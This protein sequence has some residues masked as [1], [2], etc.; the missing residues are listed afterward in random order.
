MYC[1]C[2]VY[3]LY[4]H[5]ICTVYVLCNVFVL[6]MYFIYT[7]YYKGEMMNLHLAGEDDDLYSGYGREDIAPEL[8]TE[9]LGNHVKLK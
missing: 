9:D 2:T 8:N 4:M 3:A 1:I 7:V 6:Y 5:C